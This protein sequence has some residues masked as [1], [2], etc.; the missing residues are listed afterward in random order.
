MEIFTKEELKEMELMQKKAKEKRNQEA[1]QRQAK[2]KENRTDKKI[3]LL[4]MAFIGGL[5]AYMIAPVIAEI[6]KMMI[7]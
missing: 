1:Q 4:L 3:G 6:I 2:K 7:K 5:V